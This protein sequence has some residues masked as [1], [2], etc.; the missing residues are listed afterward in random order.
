MHA[1]QQPAMHSHLRNLPAL[2]VPSQDRD[3]VPE[4][5]FQSNKER[6]GLHAVVPSIHIVS[7]EEIIRVRRVPPCA[8]ER[9]R[10]P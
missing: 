9:R 10:A 7:H 2:V 4:P 3:A 6:H 1:A 5:D 8:C